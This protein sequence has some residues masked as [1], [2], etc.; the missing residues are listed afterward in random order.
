MITSRKG[1][2]KYL[3]FMIDQ[4][5]IYENARKLNVSNGPVSYS[6]TDF[7]EIQYTE[8]TDEVH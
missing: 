6:L 8:V 4:S 1:R 3:Q 7:R 2:T 5:D